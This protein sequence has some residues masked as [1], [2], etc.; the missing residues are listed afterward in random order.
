MKKLVA[1]ISFYARVQK[2]T[3]LDVKTL[4]NEGP[5]LLYYFCIFLGGFIFLKYLWVIVNFLATLSP[6]GFP[7]E[8]IFLSLFI[9]W[10]VKTEQIKQ[11]KD[12][13]AKADEFKMMGGFDKLRTLQKRAKQNEENRQ[14]ELLNRKFND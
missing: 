9:Y 5:M 6:L 4:K 8:L 3:K 7:F 1:P 10:F 11:I 2:I 13:F 14:L 12:Y